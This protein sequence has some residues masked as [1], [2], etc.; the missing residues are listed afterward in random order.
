[1][2]YKK[3]YKTNKPYVPV[4]VEVGQKLK[5]TITRM[6]INGEGIGFYEKKLVFVPGAFPGEKVTIKVTKV[7][8][9]FLK[10]E[11]INLR[12]KSPDRVEP[13][14]SYANEVG[15]FGL[16]C[17]AYPA[18]LKFKQDLMRQAL[19]KSLN[20]PVGKTIKFVP[21]WEWITRMNIEIKPN[22]KF[23]KKTVRSW[24]DYIR[25]VHMI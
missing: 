5:L 24:P 6:G 9:N 20:L 16:E 11:L 15:G 17:L 8:F 2:T 21:P 12:S 22:F 19:K 18:Q 4:Q 23:E 13:R 7:N 25:K 3:N 10:A 1:M 14:D